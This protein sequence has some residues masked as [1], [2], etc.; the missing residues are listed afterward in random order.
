M[1]LHASGIDDRDALRRR[2]AGQLDR[3]HVASGRPRPIPAPDAVNRSSRADAFAAFAD[4][5]LAT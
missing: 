2:K 5:I 1:E 3:V 4:E